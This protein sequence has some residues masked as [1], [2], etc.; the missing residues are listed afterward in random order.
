MP[1]SSPLLSRSAC[2]PGRSLVLRVSPAIFKAAELATAMCPSTRTKNAGCA[3]D[4]VEVALVGQLLRLPE[5]VVP[6][7]PENPLTRT[8]C[9]RTFRDAL[10]H[11]FQGTHAYEVNSQLRS[12]ATGE[13]TMRIVES[14]HHESAVQID[15]LC[16]RPF[17]GE[18]LIT[19]DGH[20]LASCDGDALCAR[21]VS[22]C[23]GLA[24]IGE[25]PSGVDV[26]IC[27]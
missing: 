17:M 1:V 9:T 16:L 5:G 8:G 24:R 19:T 13:M 11:F 2:P 6:S 7:A 3:C 10:S 21:T 23:E 20:D 15:D 27:E 18:H 14:R 22:S 12:S 25:M 26:G 4:A